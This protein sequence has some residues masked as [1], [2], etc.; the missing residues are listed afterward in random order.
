[1]IR[2]PSSVDVVARCRGKSFL[3]AMMAE[4]V[5][6]HSAATPWPSSRRRSRRLISSSERKLH[7]CPELPLEAG[8]HGGQLL[9]PFP[10]LAP[11]RCGVRIAPIGGHRPARP[12]RNRL[13]SGR[14]A[15]RK[16]EI[17]RRSVVS[18]ELLPMLGA[19]AVGRILRYPQDVAHQRIEPLG[20]LHAGAETR[21]VFT[22]DAVRH[23]L[24]ENAARGVAI[25]EKQDVLMAFGHGHPPL[26]E[27]L[28]LNRRS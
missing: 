1:M 22:A 23:R 20:R 13:A 19:Q 18:R 8:Q 12:V 4:K 14:I 9:A 25:G 3:A 26:V 21:E 15:Q 11:Q 27:R 5:L 6:L 24:G 16:Y 2:S 28:L 7:E 17:E 10:G